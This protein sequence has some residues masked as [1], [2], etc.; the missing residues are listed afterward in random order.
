MLFRKKT[1]PAPAPI[2]PLPLAEIGDELARLL[3]NESDGVIRT[4][5]LIV[6]QAEYH[7]A[8]DIHLEPWQDALAVRFRIDGLL[9][10]VARIAKRHQERLVARVKVLAKLVVYQKDAPQD[11][12]IGSEATPC[13]QA[14]RVATF[15][16]VYGEKA[17]LRLLGARDR[18]LPLDGLGFRRD[19]V[20]GLR[21]FGARPQGTFLLTGPS[22][23]GKTTTIYALLREIVAAR[24]E[25]AHV[26]T[27]EDPV[28]YR[29][30]AIAQTEV[31]PQAGFTFQA[32]LRA[33]LRQ[34]PEVIMV[35]E[36]RDADT[37]RTA[38]QAGLTGHLV[39][40]TI[41]SGAAA[42]VFTRL[43]DM[44]VEPFL[45]AS[46]V[47]GVL[48]QRLIRINCPHCLADYAPEPALLAQFKQAAA[49][50]TF[51]RG[52]GCERCQGIGFRGRTAIGETLM[53]DE[54]MADLILTRPRTRTL[55]TTAVENGMATLVD[56]GIERVKDGTTT[57]EELRRVLPGPL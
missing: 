16:T 4:L 57:L 55:H 29:L 47:S 12:S 8:S 31:N 7:R 17:V 34:D 41:H 27:I 18:L 44:G 26:V 52:A 15:P 50:H 38:V 56:N 3:E 5:D 32:A 51:K 21:A 54:K 53:V 22:S 1:E 48:A 49:I 13:G 6:A 9:H 36:I 25:S 19:V 2:G 42:G 28:E 39:I 45:I 40:S 11:G 30:G 14:M 46:S 10:N 20:T 43:L 37:A 33:I 35:G 24:N 23:S